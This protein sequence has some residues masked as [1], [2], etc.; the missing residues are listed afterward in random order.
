MMYRVTLVQ[1]I[2]KEINAASAEEALITAMSQ[3][4]DSD[5]KFE[6][7]NWSIKEVAE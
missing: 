3:V 4:N 7:E 2:K 5:R 6:P 1:R